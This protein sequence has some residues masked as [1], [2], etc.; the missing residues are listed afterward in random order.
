MLNAYAQ[1]GQMGPQQPNPLISL[2]PIIL[3]FVIF[4]FLLIKPQ[5][6]QQEEHKKMIGSL[7]KNDEVV[8]SGGIH[9]TIA[10]VKET[11]VMLRV[12][13][14]VKLEVQKTAIASL[15]KRHD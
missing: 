6:K 4:Y 7:K 15:K 10:N 1:A 8:T 9:G 12:D 3:I 13:D 2:M 11:T 14:N 5:K